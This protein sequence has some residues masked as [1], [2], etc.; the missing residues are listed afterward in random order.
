MVQLADRNV[1]RLIAEL[2]AGC[3]KLEI[4]LVGGR[5]LKLIKDL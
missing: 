4:E 1:R 2:R 5:E 3:S